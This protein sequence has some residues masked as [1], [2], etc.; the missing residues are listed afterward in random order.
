MEIF[1]LLISIA[2]FIGYIAGA[3]CL[4]FAQP[5]W[6]VVLGASMLAIMVVFGSHLARLVLE[7]KQEI[8]EAPSRVRSLAL[9]VQAV[10]PKRFK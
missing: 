8:E 5:L 6:C 9:M 3:V 7:E 10:L 2:A 4:L 1:I